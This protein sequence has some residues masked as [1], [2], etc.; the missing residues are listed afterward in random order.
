MRFRS[1]RYLFSKPTHALV[2]AD[3]QAI[4]LP[5]DKGD[6]HHEI[7]IVLRINRDVQK[8]D[9]VED[10]VSEIALGLDLTLRDVQSALKEKGHPWLRAKGFKHSAIVTPFWSFEG[11][12]AANRLIFHLLKMVK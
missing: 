5:K 10:V 1:T 12:K 3:G 7:E 2:Y 6:I 11:W 9:K 8:G 4:S